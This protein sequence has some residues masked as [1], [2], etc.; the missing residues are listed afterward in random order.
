M[1]NQNLTKIIVTGA[2]G[3]IGRNIIEYLC[4]DNYIFAL[5]RRTQQ[6][7]GAVAHENVEWILIDI[8]HES[9]LTTTFQNI[10]Q[11]GRPSSQPRTKKTNGAPQGVGTA[12]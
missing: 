1:K 12:A 9:S 11:K 7:V 2:S 4:E 10:K 3:L 6:E 5:A 8:A